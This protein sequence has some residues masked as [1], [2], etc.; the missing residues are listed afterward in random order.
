M[1]KPIDWRGSS[2]DDLREFPE[3]ARRVAGYELRKL[4]R[5]EL[6]DD[7]RPFPEVGSGVNE[8]RIDSPDGWF[9][10]MYVAKF[11]E[12][13]YVLHSF[14]KST[15]KTAR[16]DVEIAKTRYRAVVTERKASK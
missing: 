12:A 14:Q 13:I 5:G 8:I 4:Q 11:Q 2:L 16:N 7:W 10:V 1:E 3:A 15:R 9:R 6:P